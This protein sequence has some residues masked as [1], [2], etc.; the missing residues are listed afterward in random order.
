MTVENPYKSLL[1]LLI[2]TL[3]TACHGASNE[4]TLDAPETLVGKDAVIYGNDDRQEVYQHDGDVFGQIADQKLARAAGHDSI[5]LSSV[6][7]CKSG[8]I[9]FARVCRRA[10]VQARR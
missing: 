9:P 3:I 7:P 1:A 4:V 5:E 6:R 8:G 10:R 2:L